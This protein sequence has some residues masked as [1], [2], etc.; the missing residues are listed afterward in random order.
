VPAAAVLLSGLAAIAIA[1]GG[2][3]GRSGGLEFA[4]LDDLPRAVQDAPVSVR[5]AYQFAVANPEILS[6]VPCYCGCG[7]MGHT[8][9]LTCFA[10]S[11]TVDGV[12]YDSHALGCSICVDIAHDVMR[13]MEQG[14]DIDE[15]KS[16]V[17]VRYAQY[18]PP[19]GP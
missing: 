9:N 18:G 1:C 11:I 13:L 17:H 4:H 6:K 2:E 16:F 8:S 19:T 12:V 7:S 14:K 3:T 15:I 10:S 5:Q